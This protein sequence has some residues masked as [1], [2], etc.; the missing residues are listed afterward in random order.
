[1]AKLEF[2]KKIEIATDIYSFIFKC[3]K[4]FKWIAVQFIQITLPHENFDDRG[5]KRY[6]SIASA[7][8]E[9][10]IMLATRIE[11]QSGSSFKKAFYN[12]KPGTI[13]E[14]T[15]PKGKFIIEKQDK[16]IIFIA[17]GIGIT[18]VRSIIFD[19]NHKDKL[20]NVDLLYSNRDGNIPFKTEI[21]DIKKKN[22]SFNIYYFL[23]P[24]IISEET[25]NKIYIRFPDS[26]TYISGPPAMVSG[27][28]DLIISKGI[29]K[30]NIKTDYFPGY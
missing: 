26:Y 14:S 20:K 11:L 29:N 10:I 23:S 5:I 16:K 28:S 17:G 8:F 18:P 27:I 15:D 22:S 19:L 6:F 21:E 24:N 3:P 7:P 30:N 12:L 2:I 13:I 25:L 4:D 1:M 9:K